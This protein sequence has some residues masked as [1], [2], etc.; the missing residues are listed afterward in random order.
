M[1]KIGVISL[2]CSKNLVDTETL[3]GELK[4]F[5]FEITN[6]RAKAE[7]IVINTCGFIESAKQESID[8]ILETATLKR[9]G[10]LKLL[11]VSGCLSERY[12]ESL[13]SELP[14]VD[15]FFGVKD[16]PSL[17]L[18]IARLAGKTLRI[19]A[20]KR[21]LTTPP[22]SAYIRIADGCDNRCAY[23]AIPLI[24]GGRVSVPMETIVNEARTLIHDGVSE[25]TLIAQDTSAYGIDLYGKPSLSELIKR[26]SPLKGLKWLRILYTYP[27]TVDTELIDTI[28]SL[29]NVVNYLDMP[30]QHIDDDILRR[31]N[32]R[33]SSEHIKNIIKYAKNLAHDFIIRSTVI[34][35]F[36]GET[37]AQF[38]TLLQFITEYRLDRLGAFTYSDE[39]NTPAFDFSDKVDSFVSEER[40]DAIMRTARAIAIEQN[41]KRIGSETEVLIE[42]VGN[43]YAIGRS[44]AEAPEVD[45]KIY[46][47]LNDSALKPGNFVQIKLTAV[48]EYDIMG[49]LL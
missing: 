29:K 14:E 43:K 28:V 18:E 36:P 34:S 45:G 38:E 37:D 16:Y 33:G 19:C 31:M 5:G 13:M 41:N 25:I 2:G 35:G 47:K 12:K 6:D 49:E 46:I 22:Y 30:I 3:L 17:A 23:C 1:N 7:I 32:R 10:V 26:I 9:D 8:T 27:D 42:S 4:S 40:F 15:L 44:Y 39:D 11:V 21:I 20:P 48:K 24:R